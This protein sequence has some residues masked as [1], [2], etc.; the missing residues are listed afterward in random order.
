MFVLSSKYTGN[1]MRFCPKLKIRSKYT[2]FF[3]LSSKYTVNILFFCPKGAP[4]Q[5]NTQ[6]IENQCKAVGCSQGAPFPR[7][8]QTRSKTN[9]L[10][11]G[12]VCWQSSIGFVIK[13][14]KDLKIQN[15]QNTWFMNSQI[16]F[17][18]LICELSIQVFLMSDFSMFGES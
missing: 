5:R 7:N 9:T 13:F 8:T 6:N 4:F 17:R 15:V 10:W 2:A 3:V 11:N 16:K 18:N 14:V 1:R 12:N